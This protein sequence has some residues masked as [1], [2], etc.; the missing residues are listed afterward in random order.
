M[1]PKMSKQSSAEKGRAARVAAKKR[2]AGSPQHPSAARLAAARQSEPTQNSMTA[3]KAFGPL[4][5]YFSSKYGVEY[6]YTSVYCLVVDGEYV[7]HLPPQA[8]LPYLV[9]YL[10]LAYAPKI[11]TNEDGTESAELGD[12]N[13][14]NVADLVIRSLEEASNI[15]AG[16]V[17]GELHRY[18]ASLASKAEKDAAEA[19]QARAAA[20]R[21]AE[22][23]KLA[24]YLELQRLAAAARAEEP[25][26]ADRVAHTNPEE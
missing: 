8:R 16:K 6:I 24:A 25:V 12:V 26:E 21:V 17:V 9:E 14:I 23:E 15:F 10:V 3:A 22:G 13:V 4:L 19:A 11:V 20:E 7:F 5:R 2:A 18:Q 1:E